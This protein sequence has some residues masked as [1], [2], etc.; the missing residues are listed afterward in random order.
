M[1]IVVTITLIRCEIKMSM[2]LDSGEDDVNDVVMGDDD[3]NTSAERYT[4][5][6]VICCRR[7]FSVTV[8]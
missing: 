4:Q 7:R 3:E 2:R 5:I 8:N 1:S 6:H